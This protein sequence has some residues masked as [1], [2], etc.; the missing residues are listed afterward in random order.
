LLI[1]GCKKETTSTT[2]VNE[3]PTPT[4]I[5]IDSG[6]FSNGPHGSVSGKAKIYKTGSKFELALENFSSSNGP[7]LKVYL[8]K[9]KQ[10]VNF[11]NLGSLKSTAGH[12]LYAIP[13]VVNVQDFKYALIHCQQFNHLFGF[14]ELRP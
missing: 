5:A 2:P 11:V 6:S 10:P 12:Q 1:I 3:M 9:E 14:A 7:D 4:A 13:A 8:S